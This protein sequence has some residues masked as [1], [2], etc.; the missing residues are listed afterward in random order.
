MDDS[1][2][3]PPVGSWR[4]VLDAWRGL[5]TAQAPSPNSGSAE[6]LLFVLALED[7]LVG[8]FSK[9]LTFLFFC[10]TLVAAVL[11]LAKLMSR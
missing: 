6:W 7:W 8:E 5:Q 10:A 11:A 4:R 3:N 9:W 2:A 1:W